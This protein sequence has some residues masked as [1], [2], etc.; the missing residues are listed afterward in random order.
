MKYIDFHTHRARNDGDEQ[1]LEIISTHPHKNEAPHYFTLGY[2]PWWTVDSL[3]TEQLQ[4]LEDTYLHNPR[5][6]AIG[7]CGLDKLKGPPMSQQITILEQQLAL[8]TKLKAPVIIHCVRAYQQLLDLKPKYPTIPSWAI[9]GYARNATLAKT[10]TD[11]GFFLSLR[12]PKDPSSSIIDTVNCVPHDKILL[13]TD[14]CPHVSI[15]EVYQNYANILQIELS[16]ICSQMA[17]NVSIFFNK[18]DL[19]TSK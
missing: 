16:Q 13:E 4:L 9:H 3:S 8:A 5:C 15:Q 14:S 6:L 17:Q 2:H 12:I 10:L 19:S 1:V 11:Q 7:E 18:S